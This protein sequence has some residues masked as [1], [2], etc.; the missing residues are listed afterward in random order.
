MTEV[1]PSSQL[2]Y[3]GETCD[4][5]GNKATRIVHYSGDTIALCRRCHP[6]ALYK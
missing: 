1:T 5:C 6:S 4:V 3:K 2:P